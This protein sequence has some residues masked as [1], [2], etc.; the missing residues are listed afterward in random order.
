M[1][2]NTRRT[3]TVREPDE[4][5]TMESLGVVG[6]GLVLG[7]AARLWVVRVYA[8]V[9]G[10]ML[11]T[12]Q[13]GDCVLVNLL[14][15][16]RL[17]GRAA[18]PAPGDV[19]VFRAPLPSAPVYVKR[20]AAGPGDVIAQQH[21]RLYRN[22]HPA[23]EPYAHWDERPGPDFGPLTVPPGEYFLLGDNR[24]HSADSRA[25]GTVRREAVL[26]RAWRVIWSCRPGFPLP[27]WSRLG[28]RVA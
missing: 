19:L 12:I 26:G 3:G 6:L 20:V 5:D 4:E 21:G 2:K 7:L 10:S 13:I 16:R 9:S 27:R 24:S 18:D 8:V 25:W 23:D 22:G 17:W 1:E 28:R 11:D 15:Y 14:A